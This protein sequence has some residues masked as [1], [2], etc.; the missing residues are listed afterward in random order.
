M[1][2]HGVGMPEEQRGRPRRHP[3][4]DRKILI[5]SCPPPWVGDNCLD[6]H[7]FASRFR[8]VVGVQIRNRAGPTHQ[9]KARGIHS[10][11]SM[12]GSNWD[13]PIFARRN[14]FAR[15]ARRLERLGPCCH[16]SRANQSSQP[17][18]RSYQPR[19]VV[20]PATCGLGMLPVP[21]TSDSVAVGGCQS[22]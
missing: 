8:A 9:H 1:F 15:Q 20:V 4:S 6:A 2:D 12:Y 3:L 5:E 16:G 14:W 22:G 19:P 18:D 7:I 21:P 13:H 17:S 11:R 10:S